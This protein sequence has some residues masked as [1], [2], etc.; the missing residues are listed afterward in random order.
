MHLNL[1]LSLIDDDS[2]ALKEKLPRATADCGILSVR[3]LLWYIN[4]SGTV[5]TQIT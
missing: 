3:V 2:Q 5:C 1:K 4:G